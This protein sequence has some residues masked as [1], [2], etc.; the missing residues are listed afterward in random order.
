MRNHLP[1]QFDDDFD[2]GAGGTSTSAFLGKDDDRDVPMCGCLSVKY[3]QPYFDI[4]TEDIGKRIFVA[5]LYTRKDD[6]FMNLI[7]EKPDAYGPF[8]VYG[9]FPIELLNIF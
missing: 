6:S 2:E 7:R 4:E 3:Y 9:T 5:S 8:W 1:S